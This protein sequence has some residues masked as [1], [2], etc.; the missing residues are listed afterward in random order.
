MKFISLKINNLLSYNKLDNFNFDPEFTV[1]VGPNGSGKSNL[2]RVLEF[3]SSVIQLISG[4]LQDPKLLDQLMSDFGKATCRSAFSE[5]LSSVKLEVKFDEADEQKLIWS[6]FT[7]LFH[8]SLI[9]GFKSYNQSGSP[10]LTNEASQA[11]VRWCDKIEQEQLESLY[12][13]T[14]ILE[15]TR[16]P[17]PGIPW[18]LSLEFINPS[19]NGKPIRLTSNVTTFPTQQ[20][21][22]GDIGGMS[23]VY[24][25]NWLEELL[26]LPV[27]GSVPEDTIKS[28]DESQFKINYIFDIS[29]PLLVDMNSRTLYA[30]GVGNDTEYLR[31]LRDNTDIMKFPNNN[32][33]PCWFPFGYLLRKKIR[34][35]ADSPRFLGPSGRPTTVSTLSSNSK[36]GIIDANLPTELLFLKNGDGNQRTRYKNI[37]EHFSELTQGKHFEL[38]TDFADNSA[39]IQ[40]V[41]IGVGRTII[42]PIAPGSTVDNNDAIKFIVTVMVGDKEDSCEVP[43]E[44]SGSGLWDVLLVSHWLEATAGSILLADEPSL[45]LHPIWQHWLLDHLKKTKS[46][47]CIVT[48]SSHLLPSTGLEDLHKIRLCRI[49]DSATLVQVVPKTTPEYRMKRWGQIFVH[50]SDAI[51]LLFANGIILVEGETEL[52]AFNV[53]FDNLNITDNLPILS[54][55]NILIISVDGDQNFGAYVSLVEAFKIPWVIVADGD[56]L[57]YPY[58][59]VN[60]KDKESL[61]CQ[62]DSLSHANCGDVNSENHWKNHGVFTLNFAGPVEHA[63]RDINPTLWNKMRSEQSKARQGRIFALET[64]KGENKENSCLCQIKDLYKCLYAKLTQSGD[65]GDSST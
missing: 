41:P 24:H 1:I 30:T 62:L 28:I 14:F 50:D 36:P 31:H 5:E 42:E 52:G 32:P 19:N 10:D 39:S 20:L 7:A 55:A 63:L 38:Q 57:Q 64:L 48:H 40:S 53:W 45:T 37:Q 25:T 17:I 9:D 60:N 2:F 56:V 33:I 18:E 15:K 12:T 13:G 59:L 44:L 21:T 54:A 61:V 35:L 51:R 46:Q 3:I 47:V 6:Y 23:G 22:S 29:G 65:I 43:L 8:H 34:L 26:R 27:N 58:R 11:I 49:K 16:K 4:N